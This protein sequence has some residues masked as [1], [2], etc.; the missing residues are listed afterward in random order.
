[1][2]NCEYFWKENSMFVLDAQF[3]FNTILLIVNVIVFSIF[4]VIFFVPFW[5]CVAGKNQI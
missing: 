3:I 5:N 4:M 1:M 2:D